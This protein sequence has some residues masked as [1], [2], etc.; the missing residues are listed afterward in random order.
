[1]ADPIKIT[2]P[3]GVENLEDLLAVISDR[4]LEI[5]IPIAVLMY[6]WA[7][8]NL[9]IAAGDPG[10]IKKAKDIMKW[11]TLGLLIIFIGGGFV[12]LIRSILNAGQ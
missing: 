12:D 5:I 2:N 3:I 6:V 7:G 4:L 10:K 9:L 8:V 11:T 1:M